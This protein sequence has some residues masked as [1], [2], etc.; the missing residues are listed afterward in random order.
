LC[1]AKTGHVLQSCPFHSPSSSSAKF[2]QHGPK[3]FNGDRLKKEEIRV[4]GPGE[5]EGKKKQRWF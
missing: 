1:E 4:A 3:F 5:E 2:S